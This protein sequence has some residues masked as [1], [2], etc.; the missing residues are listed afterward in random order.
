MGV[1][2]L[3]GGMSAF[4]LPETLGQ[5]LPESMAEAQEFGK[6]QPMWGIPK[7]NIIHKDEE[8]ASDKQEDSKEK[9]NQPE[10][11]P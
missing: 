8:K 10:Y 9:L 6:G 4:F 1:L 3:S 7:S 11:A 2:F 5:R